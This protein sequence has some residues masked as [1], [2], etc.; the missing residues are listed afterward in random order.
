MPKLNGTYLSLHRQI[1]RFLYP[2]YKGGLEFREETALADYFSKPSPYYDSLSYSF[3]G[4]E[5][6]AELM[7]NME[8]M[9]TDKV[10]DKSLF[11]NESNSAHHLTYFL[12]KETSRRLDG[13]TKLL[14]INF[15]QHMDY[16]NPLGRFFCGSWGCRACAAGCDYMV[17]GSNRRIT[18]FKAE[19]S[20]GRAY[21]L[22]QLADCIKERH[23]DCAKIY[24]T[25]DMD[26]LE[27]PAAPKRTNWNPG[28][29]DFP[30]LE[31]LLGSL[32]AD[33]ITAADIT[34]FPPVD[35]NKDRE[36]LTA[37]EPY[38]ADIRKTAE[39]LCKLMGIA[40]YLE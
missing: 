19:E 2:Y 12:A 29:I 25:V 38:I 30:A 33:R 26:V 35:T 15:D 10:P 28:H 1:G 20:S 3:T 18:S 21:D 24:V 32:P 40:P 9:F 37:L 8:L 23:G 27:N 14:V 36:T 16:G 22:T 11:F 6:E 17:V 34:G 39:T 5:P 4:L 7:A 13:G 31:R